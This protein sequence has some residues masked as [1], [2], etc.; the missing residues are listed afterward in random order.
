MC[1]FISNCAFNCISLETD[2]F[3]HILMHLLEICAWTSLYKYEYMLVYRHTQVFVT[4]AEALYE[5][6]C[7]LCFF[8]IYYYL[9]LLI[10]ENVYIYI[11]HKS[12]KAFSR[13]QLLL[14]ILKEKFIKNV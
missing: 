2:Y 8:I 11:G 5:F 4:F 1:K 3:E 13:N 9:P 7:F 14:K 12:L 10:L 6:Y